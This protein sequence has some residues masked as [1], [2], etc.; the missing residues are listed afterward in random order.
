[1]WLEAWR[2][3]FTAAS[4]SFSH[5]FF[6]SAAHVLFPFFHPYFL[7]MTFPSLEWLFNYCSL[8][9]Y[10]LVFFLSKYF[11]DSFISCTS[12]CVVSRLIGE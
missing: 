8:S 2:I 7:F 3:P 9:L 12:G 4:I 5:V 6:E 11:F 10:G 1:M